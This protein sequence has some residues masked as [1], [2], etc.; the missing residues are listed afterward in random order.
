M[1]GTSTD[2]QPP[3]LAVSAPINV[4]GGATGSHTAAEARVTLSGTAA[5]DGVLSSVVWSNDRGGSGPAIGT[6]TWTVATLPL[7]TGLN[8]LRVTAYDGA[9]HSTT[10]TLLITSRAAAPIVPSPT[11]SD[12]GVST[13]RPA[14]AAPSP[15]GTS[16]NCG[17]GVRT[18]L[19][20]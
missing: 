6:T 16:A 3:T 13:V 9:N 20:T 2:N 10:A 1:I 4:A 15:T 17:S 19:N 12:G 7:A 8:T 14:D 11:A 5:D 18:K